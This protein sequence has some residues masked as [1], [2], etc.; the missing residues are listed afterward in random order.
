MTETL[1]HRGPDGSGIH[2]DRGVALGHRRLNVIDIEG[3][4]QPMANEDG[5]VWVTYNGEIYNFESLRSD[6]LGRGHRFVTRCDT[7]VLV[8]GYEEWGEGLVDRLNGMFAF[9][10]WDG[11]RRR[12]LLARDR[13]GQKPLFYA[14]LDDGRLLFGSEAKALAAH[15]DITPAVDRAGLAHYLTYE[16]LPAD[17]SMFAGVRKILPGHLLT[18]EQGRVQ[19]HRYWDL[20]FT[21]ESPPT[22]R[23]AVDEF[24]TRFRTAVRRRLIADV[25]LG[26]FL[27]GGVDSSAVV[28]AMAEERPPETIKTFSIGFADRRYSEAHMARLVANRLGTDHHE[29]I[30]QPADLLDR[31]PKVVDTLDEPFGD[32]SLLPTHLLCEFTREFVT[33]ALGGDGGDELLMGY[34]TFWADGPARAYSRIPRHLR[35][36]IHRQAHG[37]PV[38]TGYFS[39]DFVIKSFLRAADRDPAARHALWLASFVPG[40]ADDPLLPERRREVPLD[41]VLAPAREAYASAPDPRHL[42]RLSYQYCK[43]YLAD[44]ILVK[45]DRASMAVSLEARSPFLDPDLVTFL[46]GL[47]PRMKL[48]LGRH[49]KHVL[50]RAM[51][52]RLPDEVLDRKKQGFAIPVADWLKGPLREQ[53]LDLLDP[54]RIKR[55]GFFRPEVV[56]RLVEEHLRGRR[57]NRKMLW[58]LLSFELWRDRY[59]ITS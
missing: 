16:Y 2:R 55:A 12:A 22:L 4:A 59:A 53:L 9:A 48:F 5:T 43:T 14:H 41:T 21:G 19:Q 50:K 51:R 37:M 57:D 15:P 36:I 17:L 35:R 40:S 52:G 28:A 8:H 42:Q 23:A 11:N 47:P 56:S 38:D 49:A 24:R 39:R 33:V 13:L 27:S 45:V 7:E 18:Y 46:T 54:G 26:V 1:V 10:I 25:P 31:L 30:V 44:D 58:T 3:G 29:H 20:P 6:L 32:A 34:P